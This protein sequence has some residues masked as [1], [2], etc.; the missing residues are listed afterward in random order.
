MP[1][2]D[3]FCRHAGVV[4]SALARQPLDFIPLVLSEKQLQCDD[5]T[6][7][8][9]DLLRIYDSGAYVHRTL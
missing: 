4:L 8:W 9:S 2:A 1:G 6:I 7:S 5:V 3:L